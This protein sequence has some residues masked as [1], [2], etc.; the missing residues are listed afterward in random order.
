RE[1]FSKTEVRVDLKPPV[2]L[3]DFVASSKL[4]L[5]LR[6]YLELVMANNTDIQIQRLSVEQPK[7]AIMRA[8]GAFDP[9]AIA[10]F[11]STRTKTPST[12]ALAG[13][14]TVNSLSQ[15][16]RFTV[17][18]TLTSGTQYNVTF[19]GSKST[20]NSGFQNFNPALNTGV[21]L[22]FIQPLIR[23]RGGAVNRLAIN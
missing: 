8:F 5:S 18:Q 6:S 1:T 23:N 19:T 14:S 9:L 21:G 4:E 11:S 10:S 2:R 15:P 3:Q 17:Q 20:T 16:A 13:A 7:N 12:D 22:S